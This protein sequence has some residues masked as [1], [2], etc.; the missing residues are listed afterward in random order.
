MSPM[1]QPL[2]PAYIS[3]VIAVHDARLAA[4]SSCGLGPVSSPPFAS[5][6]SATT[7]CSRI[8]RS[9]WKVPPLRRAIALMPPTLLQWVE[10]QAGRDLRVEEGRLG[11]HRLARRR[12]R[13]DLLDRRGPEQERGVGAAGLDRG[14]RLVGALG[15]RDAG[16]ARD[17]VLGHAERS[18][19]D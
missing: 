12:D 5:G 14:D 6:S 9:C 15:V 8:S 7:W 13:P 18:L 2:R 10:E 11:R 1:S 16:L 3:I 4:S 17:V 19:Q